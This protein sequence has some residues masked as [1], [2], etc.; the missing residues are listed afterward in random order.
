MMQRAIKTAIT[1]T[2]MTEMTVYRTIVVDDVGDG[3]TDVLGFVDDDV[4]DVFAS[5][6]D[7][8]TDVFGSVAISR[9]RSISTQRHGLYQ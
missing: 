6:D 4:T 2:A 1:I 3:V 9:T 5:V 7:G 8:V